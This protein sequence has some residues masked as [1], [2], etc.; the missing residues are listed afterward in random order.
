MD[1]RV[2]GHDGHPLARRPLHQSSSMM[3]G[4]DDRHSVKDPKCASR[5]RIAW[6][7]ERGVSG[8]LARLSEP[9]DGASFRAASHQRKTD[10]DQ[11]SSQVPTG[12]RD[13]KDE[14]S[15]PG[16][17]ETI[18]PPQERIVVSFGLFNQ[19]SI[20]IPELVTLEV[21]LPKIVDA[22]CLPGSC[23]SA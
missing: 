6:L 12:S 11:D 2:H 23:K 4:R 16:V 21:V 17:T 13:A 5:S 19:V 9:T 1:G 18:P 15:S 3:A 20:V 10:S 14:S 22:A 7:K 8:L